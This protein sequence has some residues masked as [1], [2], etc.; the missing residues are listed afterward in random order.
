MASASSR[1]RHRSGVAI[2]TSREPIGR[3]YG[4]HINVAS[5]DVSVTSLNPSSS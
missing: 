1:L 5:I 2:A 4:C 3:S